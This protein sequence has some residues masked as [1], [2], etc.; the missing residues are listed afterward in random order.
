MILIRLIIASSF[1]GMCAVGIYASLSAGGIYLLLLPIFA[2]FLVV[3]AVE[4]YV[5]LRKRK[6]N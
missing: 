6:K 5:L 4:I 1:G 2:F 3:S